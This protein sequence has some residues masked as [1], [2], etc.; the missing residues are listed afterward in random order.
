MIAMAMAKQFFEEKLKDEKT[1]LYDD[2]ATKDFEL[3]I[4]DDD[5]KI[6]IHKS[7]LENESEVFKAMFQNPYIETTENRVEIH[8]F[9]YENV[10]IAVRLIYD[11]HIRYWN[12]TLIMEL[13]RFFDKYQMLRL[14]VR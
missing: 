9:D 5:K 13:I 14:K 2:D 1:R 7:L 11:Q 4:V 12:T 6:R 8:D 10:Y 3:Y